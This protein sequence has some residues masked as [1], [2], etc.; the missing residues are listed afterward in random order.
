MVLSLL[1]F[2]TAPVNSSECVL[3]MTGFVLFC[4]NQEGTPRNP[5][6]GLQEMTQGHDNTHQ[7]ILFNQETD[8]FYSFYNELIL[9]PERQRL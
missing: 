6:T 9:F 8:I 2:I 1:S 4:R 5:M 7:M 3:C